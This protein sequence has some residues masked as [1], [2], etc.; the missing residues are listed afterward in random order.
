MRY[1][2]AILLGSLLFSMVL[3]TS[4]QDSPLTVV[5][6]TSIIADV[7]LQIGGEYV[8]VT[9]LVSPDTD[10]H[11]F[12]PEPQDVVL[13]TEADLV[14]VNGAGLEAFLSGLEGNVDPARIVTVS[15]GI[16]MLPFGD[17]GS[18]AE[19]A[20]DDFVGTLGEEGVCGDDHPNEALTEDEHNHGECDP[21][22]WT[23]PANIIVWA[24]NI[25]AAFAQADPSNSDA[26]IASADSYISA[27]E[28]LSVEIE[29]LLEVIPVEQRIIV[30][31]HE[32][33]GYFAHEYGFEVVGVVIPGGS[34]DAEPSPREVAALVDVI[35]YEGVRA[36]FTEQSANADLAQT[37]AQEV[38]AT[39][40]TSLR[41]DSLGEPGSGA[42]TYLGYMRSN[43]SA[44]VSGLTGEL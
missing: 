19:H 35:R 29:S 34:T 23:N 33:L 17:H 6:T 18:G 3:P 11:A 12:Q 22:V 5:A 25:A 1:L 38:G 41:S 26:Y 4:A 44:I 15:N 10:I 2:I 32:F 39:S 43:V 28:D 36:L 21:H 42:E 37:I 40:V 16:A 24:R 13:L 9:A 30:T 27:L 31:N 14:L 7:A 8:A 20:S